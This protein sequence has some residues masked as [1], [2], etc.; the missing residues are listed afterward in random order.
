ML[1]FN[2]S[3]CRI[4][5]QNHL[6]GVVVVVLHEMSQLHFYRFYLQ[7]K[8]LR[9]VFRHVSHQTTSVSSKLLSVLKPHPRDNGCSGITAFS[10]DVPSLTA[11]ER[12]CLQQLSAQNKGLGFHIRSR[13]SRHMSLKP[14]QVKCILMFQ[15]SDCYVSCTYRMP[16]RLYLGIISIIWNLLLRVRRLSVELC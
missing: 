3:W 6:A 14:Y 13:I 9:R 10:K 12:I 7:F 1:F 16:I 4:Y 11:S 5:H 15:S 8:H 2:C